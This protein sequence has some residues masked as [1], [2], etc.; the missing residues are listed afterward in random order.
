MQINIISI[1]KFS[2]NS[3]NKVLFEDYLKKTKLKIKLIEI[4]SSFS[5]SAGEVKKKEGELIL[6]K[7]PNNSKIILLDEAGE[8]FTS[9]QFAKKIENF[10]NQSTQNLIFIIGGANGVS[11]EIKQKANLMLSFGKMTLP[12][13]MIRSVIAEQ[14]YRSFLIIN[15]HPYHK[16]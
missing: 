5:G 7:I 6:A 12:H 2:K 11:E 15:N 10:Q 3:P 4:S 14:L 13:M 1:G 16:D 8:T 9:R